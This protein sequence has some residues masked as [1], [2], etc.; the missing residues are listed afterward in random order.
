MIK[1]GLAA[2]RDFCPAYRRIGSIGRIIDTVASGHATRATKRTLRLTWA[3]LSPAGSH[4]LC[5]AHLLDHLV[6]AQQDCCRQLD[7]N[8]PGRLQVYHQFEFCRSLD[9]QIGRLSTPCYP[10]DKLGD[11][12]TRSPLKSP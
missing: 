11:A 7:T 12:H 4:Q 6:G 9:G 10:V 3:G 8:C 2:M 5:L 1:S